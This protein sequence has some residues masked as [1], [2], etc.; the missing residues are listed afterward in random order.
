MKKSVW[1]QGVLD[2]EIKNS[3]VIL[4]THGKEIF[5]ISSEDIVKICENEED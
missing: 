2:I 1:V 4:K 3:Q 5:K